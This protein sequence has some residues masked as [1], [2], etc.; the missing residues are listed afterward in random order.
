MGLPGERYFGVAMALTLSA[1]LHTCR[2]LSGE[3]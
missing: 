1:S 2:V 3:G